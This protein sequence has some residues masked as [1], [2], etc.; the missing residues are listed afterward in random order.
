MRKISAGTPLL[1]GVVAAA[2]F[3]GTAAADRPR[4][5]SFS[6]SF[7]DTSTCPGITITATFAGRD[8]ILEETETSLTFHEDVVYTL[9]ANDKTLTDN[10]HFTAQFDFVNGEFRY[11]GAV[12]NIQAPGVGKVLMDVGI[13]VFDENGNV[14]HQ[15][16]P[17]PGFYGDVQGLCDYFADP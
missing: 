12:Y 3:A 13:L 11:A 8:I 5:E 2:L 17:H 10:D 14:V 15:G 9:T 6:G 1:V 4:V 16:G 7:G